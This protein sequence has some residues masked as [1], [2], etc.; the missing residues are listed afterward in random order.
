M[1]KETNLTKSFQANYLEGFFEREKENRDEIER[2]KQEHQK[3]C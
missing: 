1:R 2:E 3:D